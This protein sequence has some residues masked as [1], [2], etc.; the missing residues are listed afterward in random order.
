[1][2][3]PEVTSPRLVL[4][5]LRWEAVTAIVDGNRL[6]GWAPDY[7]DGG[8][9]V[10]A[11]LLDRQGRAAVDRST[12]R[13][14]CHRQVVERTTDLVVGGIGFLGPPGDGTVEVG[15]GIVPS[16]QGRG[17][18]TEALTALVAVA[19]T[20]PGVRSVWAGT[21]PGNLASQTVLERAGFSRVAADEGD[22]HTADLADVQEIRF[23]VE[24]RGQSA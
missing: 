8:D 24:R 12:G 22:D 14:W 9:R 3:G 5:P 4:R 23:V 13:W 15:Y 19:W 2:T 18:A 17:Y 21:D 20:D 1:M 6:D 11:G 7:P 16:R 10:I